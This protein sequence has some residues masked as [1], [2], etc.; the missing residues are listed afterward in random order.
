[1][2]NINKNTNII[3]GNAINNDMYRMLDGYKPSSSSSSKKG[4]IVGSAIS[5]STSTSSSAK[6]SSSSNNTVR[7][8]NSSSSSSTRSN[9]SSSSSSSNRSSNQSSSSRSGSTSTSSRSSNSSSRGGSFS[10]SGFGGNRYSSSSNTNTQVNAVRFTNNSTSSSRTSSS[11]ASV[12]AVRFTGNNPVS[13]KAPLGAEFLNVPVGN[14]K[15]VSAGI[16]RG[17]NSRN[18]GTISYDLNRD[19]ANREKIVSKAIGKTMNTAASGAVAGA[20]GPKASVKFASDKAKKESERQKESKSIFSTIR[21]IFSGNKK[22]QSNTAKTISPS[23]IN[24]EDAM[25]LK[26]NF[27]K[28]PT[29]NKVSTESKIESITGRTSNNNY[30]EY[31]VDKLASLIYRETGGSFRN[32]GKSEEWFA[33][34]NTAAVAMNNQARSGKGDTVGDRICSL[35]NNV[36]SGLSD[37][38][39]TDFDTVT[40]GASEEQKEMVRNAAKMALSGQYTLPSNMYLQAS[41]SIVN[42]Y[43]NTWNT[44]NPSSGGMD[45]HI[46]YEGSSASTTDL[47]GNEVPTDV[48]SYRNEAEAL[49]QALESTNNTANNYLGNLDPNDIRQL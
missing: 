42:R 45:V 48:E 15:G 26:N 14:V 43:G 27:N 25:S 44:H 36:Y 1:M 6:S 28:S 7:F 49:R 33:F 10:G 18:T 35:S 17:I 32:S 12:N 19:A 22:K 20:L 23:T 13:G 9:T 47:Y 21:N 39:N 2:K 41:A 4:N 30:T 37:Y 34:L 16:G 3:G 24:Y 29:A 31:D 11:T 46:G 40:A 8:T 38:A 5:K